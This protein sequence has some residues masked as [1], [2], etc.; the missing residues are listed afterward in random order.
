MLLQQVLDGFNQVNYI[1]LSAANIRGNSEKYGDD[2]RVIVRKPEALDW[3][4]SEIQ[5][6]HKAIDYRDRASAISQ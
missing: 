4:T 3:F 5:Y 2:K 6:L 1:F